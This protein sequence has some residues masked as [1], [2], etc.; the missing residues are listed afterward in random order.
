M[1]DPLFK[2]VTRPRHQWGPRD[3][4]TISPSRGFERHFKCCTLCRLTR[5]TVI[6]PKGE[7]WRAYRWEDGTEFEQDVEPLCR[8]E[9]IAEAK[10]S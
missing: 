7:S 5:L 2:Q 1:T 10:A 3:H 9:A 8:V 4:H 6:P